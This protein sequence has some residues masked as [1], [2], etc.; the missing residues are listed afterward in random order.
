MIGA[1]GSCAY[2]DTTSGFSFAVAKTRLAFNLDAVEAVAGIVA[3]AAT[4]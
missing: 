3:E 1:G 2:A 4:N